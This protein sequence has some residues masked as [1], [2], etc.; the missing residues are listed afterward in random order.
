MNERRQ[1]N[2]QSRQLDSLYMHDKNNIFSRT[3]KF[4]LSLAT[5]MTCFSVNPTYAEETSAPS[6]TPA[7]ESTEPTAE[8]TSDVTIETTAEPVA[9]ATSEA[10][11]TAASDDSELVD[12]APAATASAD[13]DE[14]LLD[15]SNSTVAYADESMDFSSKRLIIGTDDP[16]IISKDTPIIGQYDNI[17]LAQYDTEEAARSAYAYYSVVAAFVEPDSVLS[18]AEDPTPSPTAS[19]DTETVDVPTGKDATV[20]VEEATSP[21]Q[22]DYVDVSEDS[23]TLVNV[24]PSAKPESTA[25]PTAS[26]VPDET[27]PEDTEGADN[28]D[29]NTAEMTEE[30]NPLSQATAQ[31]E[32]DRTDGTEKAS[33]TD[34]KTIALLDTGVGK[35]PNVISRVSMLGDDPSDDNGH[36]TDMLGFILDENPDAEVL[37]IKVLD[38]QAYGTTSSVLAG[39][40]YADEQGVSIINLSMSAVKNADNSVIARKIEELSDKGIVVVAAA[41]NAG[42][43][44][45]W[46]IPG[47]VDK[48]FVVGSA[49]ADGQKQETS[50][51]GASIDAYIASNSTSEA[52]ART[53]GMIELSLETGSNIFSDPTYIG[54]LFLKSFV[55]GE[56]DVTA[57]ADDG[58]FS[59][60]EPASNVINL[61]VSGDKASQALDLYHS[62]SSSDMMYCYDGNGQFLLEK[63]VITIGNGNSNKYSAPSHGTNVVRMWAPK[64]G[65]YFGQDV[66]VEVKYT[67]EMHAGDGNT[68]DFG[69]NPMDCSFTLDNP[70][71]WPN[72]NYGPFNVF[73]RN[74]RKV[75]VSI[76]FYKDVDTSLKDTNG[77]P[78]ILNSKGAHF[79]YGGLG[80][81]NENQLNHTTEWVAPIDGNTKVYASEYNGNDK[82]YWATTKD[83]RTGLTVYYC[84]DDV[85]TNTT[86]RFPAHNADFLYDAGDSATLEYY[87]GFTGSGNQTYT[88]LGNGQHLTNGDPS[89]WF[90]TW[91]FSQPSK[92]M[93]Y[94]E[95]DPNGG[96]YKDLTGEGKAYQQADANAETDHWFIED[97]GEGRDGISTPTREGYAF[98]GW[99]VISGNGYM[100]SPSEGKM[101]YQF[102][103]SNGYIRA[104]WRHYMI[105]TEAVNGLITS[106]SAG[107]M[108]TSGSVENILPGEDRTIS[109][110]PNR[111]YHLTKVEVWE[112]DSKSDSLDRQHIVWANHRDIDPN[113]APDNFQFGNINNDYRIKVTYEPSLLIINYVEDETNV[114]LWHRAELLTDG[115]GDHYMVE[116]PY[117]AGYSVVEDGESQ[118]VVEGDM[119][120][121]THEVTVR[122][123]KDPMIG[124]QLTVHK[125]A[126]PWTG[127][128][129]KAGD[130][131]KY[132]LSAKYTGIDA[133][134]GVTITDRIPVGPTY[135]DGS[136]SDGGTLQDGV[137]TWHFDSVSRSQAKTVTYSVKVND[138]ANGGSPI[139][140]M[141]SWKLDTEDQWHESD[142]TIH[143][144]SSEVAGPAALETIKD[145]ACSMSKV[146]TDWHRGNHVQTSGYGQD[147]KNT[148]RDGTEYIDITAPGPGT[149]TFT[150]VGA[151]AAGWGD[152]LAPY[153]GYLKASMNLK[154]GETIHIVAPGTVDGGMQYGVWDHQDYQAQSTVVYVN[155][156]KKM[157]TGGSYFN[158]DGWGRAGTGKEYAAGDVTVIDARNGYWGTNWKVRPG[159]S[160]YSR[161]A[162]QAA[163][164]YDYY[165]QHIETS[166]TSCGGEVQKS[167]ST[168]GST[169]LVYASGN[170]VV[171]DTNNETNHGVTGTIPDGAYLEALEV[172]ATQGTQ[173]RTAY[174]VFNG[175]TYTVSG[176]GT[177]RIPMD[178]QNNHGGQTVSRAYLTGTLGGYTNIGVTA[179]YHTMVQTTYDGD[180]AAVSGDPNTTATISYKVTIRNNGSTVSHK[181]VVRDP[182]PSGIDL[183]AG[184]LKIMDRGGN[185][186]EESVSYN[187]SLNQIEAYFGDMDPAA[188]RVISFSGTVNR[189]AHLISNQADFGREVE[190]TSLSTAELKHKS[191]I[192]EHFIPGG[193]TVLKTWKGDADD[194]SSRPSSVHVHL[195]DQNKNEIGTGDMTAANGWSYTWTG[196]NIKPDQYTYYVYED[197]PDMYDCV[198]Y[199]AAT[200]KPVTSAYTTGYVTLENE[201]MPK[202]D[203]YKN[204]YNTSGTDIN[205]Q[206]VQNKSTLIYTISFVNPTHATKKYDIEDTLPSNVTFVSA[207]SNGVNTNG[208]VKWSGISVAAGA[209]GRVSMRVTASSDS[210]SIITIRNTGKVWMLNSSGSRITKTDPNTNAVVNYIMPQ[211]LDKTTLSKSVTLT[212]DPNSQD[213]DTLYIKKGD[214]IY[215]HVRIKGLPIRA[216]VTL[217]DVIPNGLEYVSGSADNGGTYSSAN[218][219]MTWNMSVA[220]KSTV[221]VTFGVKATVDS[222]DFDNHA[223]LTINSASSES[224][225]VT[226]QAALITINKTIENYYEPFGKPSFVYK[227]TGSNGSVNYRM[228]PITNPKAG[229]TDATTFAVPTGTAADVTWT[230]DELKSARYALKSVSSGSTNT[231]QNGN[232]MIVTPV[233]GNRPSVINYVNTVDDWSE[234]SHEDSALNHVKSADRNS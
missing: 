59:A 111:H 49:T 108:G 233:A 112:R 171:A 194:T 76:T 193:I 82:Q 134:K 188:Y 98:D 173:N 18:A 201:Y 148:I 30:N 55:T 127:N 231:V 24:E 200:A 227:I 130:T 161:P 135:V 22:P 47:G 119:P 116:S 225:H 21:A 191:N 65:T 25:A 133:S 189:T 78:V 114:V 185:T 180:G 51:Y 66:G 187:S 104:K 32:T 4:A 142:L 50:N 13:S 207:D 85:P 68:A 219:T 202:F 83:S 156:V 35:N 208:T 79:F 100:T 36:G 139:Y 217:T 140:N 124:S 52:A 115:K 229:A 215:Y 123:T 150:I 144:T 136:A 153:G 224:N 147:P 118:K 143:K 3:A 57:P 77:T 157:S 183:V 162:G 158:R 56:A 11:S 131:I 44:T 197:L 9:S 151:Q 67:N 110:Q 163:I 218:R 195:L 196:D 42:K 172:S 90:R 1:P 222:G 174:V 210:N 155:G 99:E 152:D 214:I 28:A 166:S 61:D 170:D 37:S 132:S 41:G 19:S 198:N 175:Q 121:N 39:L 97:T 26:A 105:E 101:A 12:V 186:S 212:A 137:L 38:D 154:G 84:T 93:Y 14:T 63:P 73:S 53:S 8:A 71:N 169:Q 103:Y 141:S 205:N 70:T 69:M 5:V 106:D 64:I 45:K 164:D 192:V 95:I 60:S 58:V 122:Y 184:S 40:E 211:V 34:H 87:V 234:Y 182:I 33:D 179:I 81:T 126:D 107:A 54:K 96:I 109:Y 221:T 199:S 72:K 146:I 145:Y 213:M 120:D 7:A 113:A 232:Q 75:R 102:S 91:F 117:I 86:G 226:N 216:D 16:N 181:T 6:E 48:A 46:Y 88:D 223:V 138:D 80:L 125:T 128:F 17:Y 209:T 31:V 165:T 190:K 94:L 206:F 177:S 29:I 23:D 15:L 129:V 178:G 168:P 220:P 228:I 160:E 89:I 62:L 20:D 230:V 176:N 203:K 159:K 74:S 167:V 27:V 92:N 43:D 2:C 10:A 204:V 149:Y